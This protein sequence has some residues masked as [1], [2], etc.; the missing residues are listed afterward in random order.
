MAGV[1]VLLYGLKPRLSSVVLYAW[2]AWSFIIEMVGS[3]VTFKPYMLHTSLLRNIS[4]VPAA[5]PDWKLFIIVS[6]IGLIAGVLGLV[7][8]T[9]RDLQTE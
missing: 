5:Q 6:G 9:Y 2:I 8:F 3:V 1:G 4:L 7:L